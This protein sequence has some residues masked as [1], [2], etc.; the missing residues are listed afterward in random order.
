MAVNEEKSFFKNALEAIELDSDEPETT[1]ATEADVSWASDHLKWLTDT[2]ERPITADG[3]VVEVWEFHHET[4]EAILSAWSKHFRNHY[5]LDTEIDYYRRGYNYSRSEY[6]NKIKFPDPHEPPG[7]SIR[8]GDFG[9]ILV[10]DFLEYILG[11]WV[12]RTRYRDK[13]IRNESSKGSDI[14][15]FKLLVDGSASPDDILCVFEAKAQ[16][17]GNSPNPR[18]QEAVDDS[19]KDQRRKAESLNAI[20]QR[21]HEKSQDEQAILIERFQNPL[22]NPYIEYSG[23]A[24]LFSTNLY[25]R[26]MIQNTNAADHPNAANM[27]LLVIRGEDLMQLVHE[28]YKRAADEAGK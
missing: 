9:E 18:L 24:A 12:P 28:L 16:F 15:G 2:G 21:L 10:A 23:A 27:K 8:S 26:D 22:D 5:C 11:F 6:L 14:I 25:D 4:D 7:P 17:S 19:K 3:K 13:D 1:A 20:K